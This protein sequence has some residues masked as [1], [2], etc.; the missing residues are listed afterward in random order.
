MGDTLVQ[1]IDKTHGPTQSKM[2]GLLLVFSMLCAFTS[3][4]ASSSEKSNG[5]LA[6]AADPPA[7]GA[8][9]SSTALG[10][11]VTPRQTVAATEWTYEDFQTT[12]FDENSITIDNEI[13]PVIPGTRY[14]YEGSTIEEGKI[15][16]HRITFAVTNLTKKINGVNTVVVWESDFSEGELVEDELTFLAQDKTGNV[17]H[18]GEYSELWDAGEFLA[19]RTWW[20][21]YPSGAKAGIMMKPNPNPNMPDWSEGFAPAPYFWTDRARIRAVDQKTTVP[22]GT[23]EGV[24]VVEEFDQQEPSAIQLKYY[25]PGVGVVRVGWAGPDDSKE[26]LVMVRKEK[27]TPEKLDELSKGALELEARALGYTT[28]EPSVMRK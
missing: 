22:T 18:M 5:S 27:L 26:S 15:V 20:V 25:A 19:G 4:C 16:P 2:T 10:Q 12:N 3:A 6:A 9:S 11:S 7:G 21:G 24:V 8:A 17:W 1:N 28:A 23:F 14:E 13:Y